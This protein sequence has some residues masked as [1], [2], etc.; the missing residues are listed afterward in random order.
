MADDF[1]QKTVDKAL[2]NLGQYRVKVAQELAAA[3]DPDGISGALLLSLGLRESQLQNIVN[4]AGTDRGC[5]QITQ[6]YHGIWLRGEPGCPEGEWK[7]V[8]RENALHERYVPRFTPACAYALGM[9]QEN[10]AYARGRDNPLS[11]AIAAY[12]AG[13]GGAEKGY[14]EG[15]VDKYTSGGDY[16]DWVLR[17]RPKVNKFLK[18]H[19]NW[20]F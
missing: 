12:N 18:A 4:A 11:Y 15:N 7:P 17:H 2:K 8:D 1:S 5:F 13:R 9:L 16:S 20:R 14:K 6:V 10:L 3:G 19:P